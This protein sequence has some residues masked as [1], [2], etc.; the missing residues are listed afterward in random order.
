MTVPYTFGTATTSI[1]LS[2]LDAN[3]N[4]PITLGNTSIY[5]G[6]TTTTI[7]NLTL[8]N[9]TISSG[10][11]TISNISVTTANVTTAN[12]ATLSVTGT[13]TIATANITTG[14]I[15]TLT[16]TSITDSGLTSGR[17][18]YA[19]TAGL[20]QDSA[21]LLYSGTDLTVYGLTV[22]RGAGAI[23]TNTVLG[24]SALAFNSTGTLNIAI[25]ANANKTTTGSNNIG[26][27]Q[28][29]L[30]GNAAGAT[31]SS[32][33][34]LGD[35]TMFQLTS[36]A[37]NVAIGQSSQQFTS[38]GSNNV[39]VGNGA[40]LNNSTASNNTAIGYQ[41]GYNNTT[42][43]LTTVG[44][45][46]GYS[47]STG[48]DNASFGSFSLRYTTTGAGN[49]GYG[50][51]SLTNN[52]TGSSNTAVG[53]QALQ[54]N[55]TASNNTAVGYQAGYTQTTG[56][57][58]GSTFLGYRAG[59]SGNG[60]QQTIVG[61]DAGLLSTG[62]NNTFMGHEAG[63]TMTS[64]LGNTL[65]GRF[66]G[67]QDGLDIRTLSDYIVLSDG[68]GARQITMKE[69]QT[70]ALDSAV[71]NTGTGITFPATQSASSNANTLDDYE[72]GT[73]TPSLQGFT[74]IAYSTQTGAYT[75]IGKVVN[76]VLHIVVSG[77]TRSGADLLVLSLPFTSASQGYSGGSWGYGYG[78]VANT[79]GLPQLRVNESTT[80]VSFLNT[81]GGVLA[82]TDLN[83]A[84]PTI[85]F[86]ATYFV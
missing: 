30:G 76:I 25:G 62:S 85:A 75:K 45:L 18:T 5:L 51:Y 23:A 22:G 6:N 8:T 78:V 56:T 29:T 40:L 57:G 34:G 46:A 71:P 20:L 24:A 31:G 63:S 7:G 77:G 12:V 52:T 41:A 72:E 66:N 28:Y 15:T 67:N 37:N 35:F 4:T 86:S 27:G 2:N 54:A 60:Y 83:T 19:G 32:N 16:S 44:Y 17:V 43:S 65:I 73:W 47:N 53:M 58:G 11:V 79:L 36:G 13:A 81:A 68:N 21:N 3:F 39:S 82:G 42:G 84:T 64:G 74:S 55:T 10:N 59:Y 48:T 70:L 33:T 9:A 49:S 50:A 14:N 69:G 26:I 38:T 61:F 80:S 1:P